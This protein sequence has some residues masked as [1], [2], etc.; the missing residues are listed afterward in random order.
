MDHVGWSDYEFGELSNRCF[1]K[2]G[3]VETLIP[4]SQAV[5]SS[6]F[7]KELFHSGAMNHFG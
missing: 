5:D 7:G 3:S 1:M 4:V 2:E 6:N